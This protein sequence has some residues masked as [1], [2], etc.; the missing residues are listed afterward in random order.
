MLETGSLFPLLAPLLLTLLAVGQLGLWSLWRQQR[1]L[2]WLGAGLA[3]VG[4]GLLVQLVWVKLPIGL[5]VMLPV[6]AYV[7]GCGMQAYAIA[8]RLKGAFPARVA[9]ALAVA[10]VLAQ[11]W[12]LYID[13]SLRM[14]IQVLDTYFMAMSGL[15]LWRSGGQDQA[16][17]QRNRFDAVI[18]C[19]LL[20]TMA[21]WGACGYVLLPLSLGGEQLSPRFTQSLYWVGA[22][23]TIMVSAM[24]MAGSMFFAVLHD[25]MRHMNRERQRDPLTQLLNRRGFHEHWAT[26]S[27]VERQGRY[28]VLACDIDHFKQVN[29]T[30]GHAYGDQVLQSIA[31]VLREQVRATDLVARFGGEEFVIL[32]AQADAPAAWRVA[33]RIRQQIEAAHIA[34]TFT[35]QVTISIGV[36]WVQSTSAAALEQALQVADQQLYQAKQQGRN[37]VVLCPSGGTAVEVPAAGALSQ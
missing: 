28:A 21:L 25:V 14:R 15:S 33:E 30:Y 5:W 9:C 11:L 16:T 26:S 37:R 27:T 32:L 6:L 20:A 35:E 22:L 10:T 36:S 13:P 1:E 3:L 29:D 12:F 24:M 4:L 7:A 31:A 2:L 23:F 18:R 19:S 8:L 17:I 34:K